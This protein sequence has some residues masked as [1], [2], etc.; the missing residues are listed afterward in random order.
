MDMDPDVGSSRDM[1]AEAK[2][3]RDICK[4]YGPALRDIPSVKLGP[5]A[6]TCCLPADYVPHGAPDS[7]LTA[8]AQLASL[9]VGAARAMI[10][11]I[12]HQTQYILAEAT[13][14][15]SLSFSPLD[16][17]GDMWLG[18]VRIPRSWG[19]CE[20]VLDIDS[21]KLEEENEIGAVIIN[22]L[23]EAEKYAGR[24]YVHEG[25]R[26]R[27]YAGVPLRS[28]G[29]YIIGTLCVFDDKPRN[30]ISSDDIL[31]LKDLS[32]TVIEY[33]NTLALRDQRRR[34]ELLNRGLLS[35]ASGAL[36]LQSADRSDPNS[37]TPPPEL[38]EHLNTLGM[39]GVAL[40][41]SNHNRKPSA[42]P[43]S[44]I[45]AAQPPTKHVA[46]QTD[47]VDRST[48]KSSVSA[49]QEKVL[50][51]NSKRMFS[52]AA[53]IMAE[54]SDLAGVI[55]LDASIAAAGTRYEGSES[56]QSGVDS[57]DSRTST[58]NDSDSRYHASVSSVQSSKSK[59]CKVLGFAS[60]DPAG[61][62][63]VRDASFLEADLRRML[64]QYPEGRVFHFSATGEPL[65]S[66]DEA[67]VQ[68]LS[69][70]EGSARSRRKRDVNG[71]NK[72]MKA[73]QASLP[74]VRSVAFVP[75]WD[76]ERA[77]WFAGCMCWSNRPDRLLSAQ[78]DLLYYKVFGTLMMT[79]LARLDILVSDQAKTTFLSSIS[80]E[81][82]SPLHG[83]LGCIQFM[84]DTSVDSFQASMLQSMASCGQ[85]LQDTLSHVLDYSKVNEINRNLSKLS[86]RKIRGA[87]SV[88]L[89]A[90]PLKLRV[91]NSSIMQ[92]TAFDLGKVTE[93]V[94][95]A[96]FAG[97][98]FRITDY[99]EQDLVSPSL[100]MKESPF[101]DSPSQKLCHIVLDIA[102]MDDWNFC[103]PA[104]AWRTI[105]M[106][107]F[108]NSLKY[109]ES[110]HINVSLRT[111]E[112]KSATNTTSVTLVIK[113]SGRGISE[114][115]L[116]NKMFQP[117]RQ[118]NPHSSGTGLGLSIVSNIIQS[119]S[120]RIDVSSDQSG[121]QVVV[122]LSLPR[123]EVPPPRTNSKSLFCDAVSRLKGRRVCVL[124]KTPPNVSPL[125]GTGQIQTGLTLFVES[126]I[127]T[128]KEW[129]QMEV[130]LTDDNEG[131]E[132][133]FVI[134]PE[135]SFEYL[136]NL[137]RSRASGTKASV[138]IFVA[139]DGIEAATLRSDVRVSS[140]ESVV[141][142]IPQPCGPYK[143][144]NV[145]MHCLNR[146]D[147]PDENISPE[148]SN[149]LRSRLSSNSLRSRLS[150]ETTQESTSMSNFSR[151]DEGFT[152]I[153]LPPYS[154]PTQ[155]TEPALDCKSVSS[156]TI[157]E[158][159]SPGQGTNGDPHIL[160]TDDNA[161]NRK[162]LAAFLKKRKLKF[163]EAENGLEALLTYQE[164]PGLFPVILMD[165]SM[166]VMDGMT[167]MRSIRKYEQEH[168]IGKCKIIAL[169]GLA[170]A[171]ARL[172]AW[173]SGA[174]HFMTKPINFRD[175]DEL[176]REV[177]GE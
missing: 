94:V 48:S 152:P 119:I 85:T 128:L 124:H 112:W 12:D 151:F 58:D 132:V 73:L 57:Y 103:M 38:P 158:I 20:S 101:E 70:E 78:F 145:L 79:E 116:A 92:E 27:F 22:D 8:F 154:S 125:T 169:T 168:S 141:E 77:R 43:R 64:N 41:P 86:S 32:V 51:T 61:S 162:L 146:Y 147:S 45:P 84:Q 76:S 148:S 144:A 63:D 91:Q 36:Q 139:A 17:S 142:I 31:H 136:N 165:I 88:R 75:L 117:F 26:V 143:L 120:G 97:Q 30:D 167:A 49:L 52:R 150:S 171:S 161:I 4:L 56:A 175:L 108:G 121:T 135:A 37:L 47:H 177:S 18:N 110:G 53:K 39:L 138:T 87:N 160:I 42:V 9:R 127:V 96:A 172:E 60:Q 105:I 130:V 1:R 14:N 72:T 89:S 176:M 66:T 35:F 137:R 102:H 34:G 164:N 2:R 100:L 44:S 123:P 153:S 170:S 174:D 6:D 33:L 74:G 5:S 159:L 55:I 13:P 16:T 69:L 104:G 50:P 90:K 98:S 106:N 11:L 166:P 140:K 83:I 173:S 25:P 23:A 67:E 93:E 107:I 68:K 156:I 115:F 82:R 163:R 122:K 7:A 133:D 129:L 3:E 126:L 10:S 114:D 81:L 109:T 21:A 111:G 95:E 15:T 99:E 149:S 80:H 40:P 155:E 65:S 59:I 19:V 54:S 62:T 118:E 134:C 24:T 71:L 131:Q 46:F 29:G 28:P 157:S 113:D